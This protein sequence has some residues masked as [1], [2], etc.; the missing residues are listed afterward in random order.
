MATVRSPDDSGVVAVVGM[1]HVEHGRFD[2]DG[3]GD[4]VVS[5]I[6]GLV[7]IDDRSAD[8]DDDCSCIYVLVDDR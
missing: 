8:T 4:R 6:G 1:H 7:G 2:G 5:R 3:R